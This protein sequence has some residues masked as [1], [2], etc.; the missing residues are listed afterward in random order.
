MYLKYN[1]Y[2]HGIF[3]VALS[4][5]VLQKSSTAHVMTTEMCWNLGMLKIFEDFNHFKCIFYIYIPMSR[6]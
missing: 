2:K 3:G 6:E 1:L 4:A 5:N